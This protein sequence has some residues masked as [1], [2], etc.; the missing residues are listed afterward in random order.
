MRQQCQDMQT[1]YDERKGRYD[2]LLLQ[3]ESGMSRV[4]QE[5]KRTQEEILQNETKLHKHQ[6]QLQ[7]QDLLKQRAEG[8]L[9]LYVS[10]DPEDRKKSIR[11]RL[12]KNISEQEK[13]GKARKGM[14]LA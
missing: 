3:L 12:L 8:E 10:K 14:F 1:D 4:E 5:V 2:T 7:L 6:H 11:E 9:K 13:R